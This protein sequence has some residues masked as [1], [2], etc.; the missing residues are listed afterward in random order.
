MK[1]QR[2]SQLF[3]WEYKA[4]SLLATQIPELNL[5]EVVAI[6]LDSSKIGIG[7]I[8]AIDCFGIHMLLVDTTKINAIKTVT[9]E[10]FTLP[11]KINSFLSPHAIIYYLDLKTAA[12]KGLI[13]H[14]GN[15]PLL[16]WERMDYFVWK[17]QQAE[18]IRENFT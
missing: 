8:I 15:A 14:L 17:E 6:G 7:K 9:P 13:K 11:E 12:S 10:L 16:G 4:D 5:G 18:K 1:I 2:Q 3:K